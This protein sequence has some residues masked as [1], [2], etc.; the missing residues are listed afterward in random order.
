[1][2]KAYDSAYYHRWY[3]DPRTRVTS[4]QALERKVHLALSAAEYML[5]RRVARVLDVGC[6]EGRWHAALKRVRRD[7]EYVGVESSDYAVRTF[8]AKCNV[9]QGGFGTLRTLKLRGLFDLIVC[10]DV[11]QYVS[12]ADLG[13]GLREIRRLLGGVA[14]IEAYAR[15]DDMEGDM[16]GWIFRSASSLRREFREAGLTHCGLYCFIDANKIDA[17]NALEVCS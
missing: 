1:M 5:G 15:E 9:R 12:T 3:R 2:T 13:P 10:A 6:G 16:D 14:Y 4:T 7:V 11:L 8:G 17:V